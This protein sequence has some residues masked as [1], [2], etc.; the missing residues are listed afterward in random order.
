MENNFLLTDDL[1][2]DYAD[3]FLDTSENVR[4]EAYL[5]QHPE[6]QRR[7]QHILDEKQALATLPMESP[8]PGFTDRVMAAWAAEQAQAQKAK[9]S[10][11]WIIRFIVLAFGLFVLTPVV[12]MLIAAMQ[13]APSELPAVALPELPAIDWMAWVD[14]P[15]LMY[16]LLLLFVVSGL[17]LADKILQHQ[18]LTHKLA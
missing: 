3:G 18:R 10:S 13:M 11:D 16:G 17:R 1:L 7:L 8:D 4:V 6:W 9:G 14:S 12:V 15:V 5:K 2:W